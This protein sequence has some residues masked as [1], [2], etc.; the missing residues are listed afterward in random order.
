MSTRDTQATPD[1]SEIVHHNG[2]STYAGRDAV[3]V[4][5]AT[6]L[7][8]ALRMYARSGM[9]MTRGATPTKLLA[10]ANGITGKTYKRG[11]Y[12]KAADD[13]KVWRD[14]MRAAIPEKDERTKA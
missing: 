10:L 13:V 11:D 12:I 2:G 4:V 7:E 6:V 3:S 1:R 14:T 8:S 9:L 5:Q